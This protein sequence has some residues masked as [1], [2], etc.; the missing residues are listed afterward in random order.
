[1]VL[2]AIT[3]PLMQG[4]FVMPKFNNQCVMPSGTAHFLY[5]NYPAGGYP[6]DFQPQTERSINHVERKNMKNIYEI[7]KNCG[8]E[9]PEDKKARF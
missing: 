7:M 5:P 6:A 8:V 4:G 9:I 1:M 3:A 2:K